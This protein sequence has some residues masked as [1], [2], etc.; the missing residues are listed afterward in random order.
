VSPLNY[1]AL[2]QNA[3]VSFHRLSRQVIESGEVVDFETAL[4]LLLRKLE[5]VNELETR[6]KLL[7]SFLTNKDTNKYT[8]KSYSGKKIKKNFARSNQSIFWNKIIVNSEEKIDH[9]LF[10]VIDIYTQINFLT[11]T[12]LAVYQNTFRN[13]KNLNMEVLFDRLFMQYLSLSNSY[14]ETNQKTSILKK[15][16]SFFNKNS[17]KDTNLSLE[18]RS[19]F[20]QLRPGDVF[21]KILKKVGL[22][23]S[24]KY[25]NAHILNAHLVFILL[26]VTY[27][28]VKVFDSYQIFNEAS[29]L[30]FSNEEYE[31]IKQIEEESSLSAQQVISE[32]QKIQGVQENENLSKLLNSLQSEM[33]SISKAGPK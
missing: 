12:S 33:D 14:I 29:K 2:I 24:I 11:I 9:I 10:E 6:D 4:K 19:E 16:F 31:K 23:E 3:G 1:D 21:N 17:L 30:E 8:I 28:E 25:W 26:S 20:E 22:I 32:L 5:D 27:L 7:A 18:L 13:Y 15:F